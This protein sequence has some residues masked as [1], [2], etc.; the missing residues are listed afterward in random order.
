M[1]WYSSIQMS[2]ASCHPPTNLHDVPDHQLLSLNLLLGALPHLLNHIGQQDKL[3]CIRSF[4]L[5]QRRSHLGKALHDLA[6]LV[7]LV[8]G[9]QVSYHRHQ[10]PSNPN[11][12][13]AI[14]LHRL[15]IC[16]DFQ[17]WDSF[18]LLVDW[19]TARVTKVKQELRMSFRKRGIE[20]TSFSET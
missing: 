6:G 3:L 10:H 19:S 14:S 8:V 12:V 9:E 4:H 16:Q 13:V 5:G 11:V 1:E 7:L 17:R 20:T 15:T 18:H 2:R